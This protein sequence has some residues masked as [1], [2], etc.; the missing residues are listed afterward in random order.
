MANEAT[1]ILHGEVASKKAEQTAKETF[2]DKGLGL[3][4]PVIKIKSSEI[5][6]GKNF[7]DLLSDNK[8]LSSKSEARRA[9]VNRGLKIN[10][11]VITD[12]NKILTST[13]FEENILKI[14]HGKKKHY[15]IKII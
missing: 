7:L 5:K 11:I 9:I 14:S 6:K 10:N 8:I 13:D 12:K 1:R 15:L 2:E 4:L 3:D